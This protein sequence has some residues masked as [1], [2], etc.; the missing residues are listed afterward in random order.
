MAQKK[1]N[2]DGETFEERDRYNQEFII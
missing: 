1:A 2:G